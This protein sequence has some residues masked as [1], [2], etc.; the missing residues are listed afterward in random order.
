MFPGGR[1]EPARSVCDFPY[2]CANCWQRRFRPAMSVFASIFFVLR[3]IRETK[4]RELEEM[5]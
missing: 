1:P 4:G 5:V 3:F 2:R